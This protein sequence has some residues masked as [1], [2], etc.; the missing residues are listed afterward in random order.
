MLCARECKNVADKFQ[1]AAVVI[2]DRYTAVAMA[3]QDV[4]SV[5]GRNSAGSWPISVSWS[6]CSGCGA[7]AAR[8][9]G[10]CGRAACSAACCSPRR[11]RRTA[12]GL[13]MGYA[14]VHVVVSVGRRN[15][16]LRRAEQVQ[17]VVET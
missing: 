5:D 13:G 16:G 1:A 12:V 2:R 6:R 4:A 17:T 3:A 9:V 15:D 10:A 7:G 14:L 8:G 11:S